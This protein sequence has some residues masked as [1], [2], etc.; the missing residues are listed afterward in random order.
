MENSLERYISFLDAAVIVYERSVPMS[1]RTSFR[2]GG[3]ADLCVSPES[4]EMAVEA[5]K[6]PTSAACAR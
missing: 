1:A 6:T 4:V 3:P 5:L 2:I